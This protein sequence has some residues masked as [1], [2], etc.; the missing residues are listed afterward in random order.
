MDKAPL[1]LPP[2]MVP[3]ASREDMTSLDDLDNPGSKESPVLKEAAVGEVGAPKTPRVEETVPVEGASA[4]VGSTLH[5]WA[6]PNLESELEKELG[7]AAPAVSPTF[8]AS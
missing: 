6:S 2:G 7:S 8:P 5:A 3:S 1:P 4:G